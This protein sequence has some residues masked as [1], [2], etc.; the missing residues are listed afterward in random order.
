M[1]AA[2]K[3][4]APPTPVELKV[5]MRNQREVRNTGYGSDGEWIVAECL[6]ER[7]HAVEFVHAGGIDLSV[8][9]LLSVDVKAHLALDK[10][11][12]S[13]FPAMSAT[14]KKPGVLYPHV[15]FFAECVRIFDC[16][17][18]GEKAPPID[19]T[20]ENACALLARAPRKT[21]SPVAD[22]QGVRAA[23]LAA[24]DELHAWI[25][26]QW[27][28]AAHVVYRGNPVAQGSMSRRAWGPESFY[29][30]PTKVAAKIDLVV[31]VYFD[32][33]ESRTVLAYPLSRSGEIQW[34]KKPVGSNPTG[35]K[36]FNP[37]AIDPKFV[38]GSVEQFRREFL[39]RFL[40]AR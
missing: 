5:R 33:A 7:G 8:D 20:W 19:L 40:S 31:L 28:L 38:F 30:N 18:L 35:R 29:Q 16:P 2:R 6:R 26:T 32:G 13:R 37:E 12:T 3:A 24:R 14:I 10:K 21:R 15:V 17:A 11:A 22:P 36:T 9:G 25:E 34:G 27:G 39:R 4:A 23:Q 1:T